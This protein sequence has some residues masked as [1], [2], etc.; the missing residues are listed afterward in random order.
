M[1]VTP[2]SDLYLG[3][4]SGTS[5]DGIIDAALIRCEG[6]AVELIGAEPCP[7]A[8]ELRAQL[9]KLADGKGGAEA[10]GR[11]DAAAGGA[12]A[13]AACTL[14]DKC[15]VPAEAVRAI[16]SHGQT[17]LHRP[18]LGFSIQ[19]A[20][21]ARIAQKTGITTVA[22]FR[23]A[24]LAAGGEGAPLA[25]AFHR[26][27]FASPDDTRA[28]LNLGG[29]ANI[30][31]LAPGRPVRAFDVGP[32][33]T[34]LDALAR[35]ATGAGCDRDGRLAASGQVD[36]ALLEALLADPWFAR[37]S[38]KSTGP[39]H[40]NLDWVRSHAQSAALAS[41]DLAASLTELSAAGVARGLEM[42]EAR[43]REVFCCG[44]GVHNPELMRRLAA[45]LPASRITT[46]AELGVDPDYVEAMCFAWLARETLAG[47]PANLPEVTGA[48]RATVLGAIHSP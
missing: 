5:I 34:L 21:P 40:F 32:A 46:T 6:D 15:G 22:D 45:R 13:A 31:L 24:D 4:M 38:P 7:Y 2:Q 20:D 16:G 41:A 10:L 18:D 12:F 26:A 9:R 47:R 35:E 23:R 29:I 8:P 37:P 11:A 39:E 14:L 33:N 1:T 17:V 48:S 43:P 19:I 3:L 44:G 36:K 27:V 28:V 25:P 42:L 30:T